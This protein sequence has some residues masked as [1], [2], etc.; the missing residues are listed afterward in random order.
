MFNRFLIQKCL[1]PRWEAIW[2]LHSQ[3]LPTGR[4]I[5]GFIPLIWRLALC[6]RQTL[7]STIWTRFT[8]SISYNGNHYTTNAS[9]QRHFFLKTD[10]STKAR[11]LNFFLSF[12]L[13]IYI[14]FFSWNRLMYCKYFR[15]GRFFDLYYFFIRKD[16]QQQTTT[17]HLVL[18]PTS[19]PYILFPLS[20]CFF[21]FCSWV[22]IH[23][24]NIFI[25]ILSIVWWLFKE[26]RFYHGMACWNKFIIVKWRF[27]EV[28]LSNYTN[29]L[30]MKFSYI[31]Y[32]I[33]IYIYY[34]FS[35]LWDL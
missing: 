5:I 17:L 15:C 2:R 14:Y 31:S 34:T 26:V 16:A 11:E 7:S 12:S 9:V 35:N 10:C 18:T 20:L 25:T 22:R 6:K 21:L 33:Y 8:V 19:S 32:I 24:K 1:S 13:S 4:R 27:R 3:V 23:W 30:W 29:L 28:F